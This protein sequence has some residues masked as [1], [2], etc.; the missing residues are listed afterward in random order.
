MKTEAN[1]IG[2]Y[3]NENEKYI[4]LAKEGDEEA[5]AKLM[6]LNAGLVSGIA[7]RFVGR[8]IDYD[9]LIQIGSIGMLKAIR[10][11]DTERG[12]QFST[13][14]VPLIIGEIRKYLQ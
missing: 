8:G 7:R 13:Y 4:P 2:K 5:T 1:E 11:F 6:E 9:D 14:A 3:K 10:S 12:T